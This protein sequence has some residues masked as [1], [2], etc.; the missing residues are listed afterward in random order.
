MANG[1]S[2]LR[3]Y[4][5]FYTFS[6]FLH[7]IQPVSYYTTIPLQHARKVRNCGKGKERQNHGADAVLQLSFPRQHIRKFCSAKV[8]SGNNQGSDLL[9]IL[10]SDTVTL[11]SAFTMS[12]VSV[13]HSTVSGI[14][15][16]SRATTQL[17]WRQQKS[18]LGTPCSDSIPGVARW[19]WHPW[20]RAQTP[21]GGLGAL[22]LCRA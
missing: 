18:V 20:G 13:T 9:N 12:L 22:Q 2:F 15:H 17:K 10:L 1:L 11:L 7:H 19:G 21:A 8:V 16:P 3:D 5:Q 14:T 6:L 4:T